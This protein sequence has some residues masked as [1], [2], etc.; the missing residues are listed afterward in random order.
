MGRGI[1]FRVG[2]APK[3]L[4]HAGVGLREADQGNASRDPNEPAPRN[5]APGR[6]YRA[7]S[8]SFRQS[9]LPARQLSNMTRGGWG[10]GCPANRQETTRPVDRLRA[11]TC[12]RREPT[13]RET[14]LPLE[15]PNFPHL[16]VREDAVG[17]A[18]RLNFPAES[19]QG[20]QQVDRTLDRLRH[21]STASRLSA[22]ATTARPSMEQ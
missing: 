7:C 20:G 1:V 3:G 16:A 22:Q 10:G 8:R 2:I 9:R 5:S 21:A 14:E 6:I 15:L 12:P 18:F 11:R 17:T 4:W 19:L 13:P